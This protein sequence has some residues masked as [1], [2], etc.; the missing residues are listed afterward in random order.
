[1]IGECTCIDI[2]ENTVRKMTLGCAAEIAD[3]SF[4]LN[5]EV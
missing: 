2:H 5:F 4:S 3:F 1:M